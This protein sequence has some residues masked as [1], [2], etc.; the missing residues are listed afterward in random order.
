MSNEN[1]SK[2]NNR[3]SNQDH[4]STQL[5]PVRGRDIT[6][7][8][9]DLGLTT[10][11]RSYLLGVYTPMLTEIV[12]KNVTQRRARKGY[13]RPAADEIVSDPTKA[14]L[15]RLVRAY[16]EY[17]PIPKAPSPHEI[18]EMIQGT[19]GFEDFSLR[20]L[21]PLLG[22]EV[23]SGYR[24]SSGSSVTPS[25]ERYLTIVKRLLTNADP[26]DR[27]DIIQSLIDIAESEAQAR[28][29]KPGELWKKGKWKAD[30]PKKET[31]EESE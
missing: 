12:S 4:P 21:G 15:V 2:D 24:W 16:P 13:T 20:D 30:K 9:E 26:Q 14:L 29:L 19:P 18:Y 1:G 28:G 5:E 7:L 11:D 10:L 6:K 31:A 27:P 8:G 17:S 22:C 25:I 3:P 23:A